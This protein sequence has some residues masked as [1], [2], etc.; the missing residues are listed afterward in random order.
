MPRALLLRAAILLFGLACATCQSGTPR[1][2]FEIPVCADNGSDCA[3]MLVGW[4]N[5]D[6]RCVNLQFDS[7]N[8]GQCGRACPQSC[9]SGQCVAA[10]SGSLGECDGSCTYLDDPFNCGDC[11]VVCDRG[12]R[13]G[14]CIPDIGCGVGRAWCAGVCIDILADV[15]NCG[16]CARACPVN[17]T[18]ANGTCV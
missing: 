17:T 18:C 1:W 13:A 5:C 6:S 7:A 9:D 14:A 16:A 4:T 10:C 15:Q 12:C 8:C 2:G 11:G 3:C